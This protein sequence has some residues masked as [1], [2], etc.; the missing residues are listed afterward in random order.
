[1]EGE[2]ELIEALLQLDD[3]DTEQRVARQVED[4]AAK[5]LRQLRKTTLA[6]GGVEAREVY[7]GHVKGQARADDLAIALGAEVRAQRLVTRD[8]ILHGRRHGADVQ[9]SAQAQ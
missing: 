4:A 8:E 5:L 9:L 1:M 3:P 2:D 6:R 7:E